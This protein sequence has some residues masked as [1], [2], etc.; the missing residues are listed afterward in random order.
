MFDR[1]HDD[2][3]SRDPYG[4]AL[5]EVAQAMGTVNLVFGQLVDLMRTA[6]DEGFTTGPGL[7]SPAQWL[8]WRAGLSLGQAQAVVR[9]A[10]RAE[11][12]PHAVGAL[13]AGDLTI[14]QVNEIARYVP[15]A[16]DRSA[17]ALAK[18]ATVSQ[19]RRILPRYRW[20]D[21]DR[22]ARPRR[23]ERSVAS[24]VDDRGWWLR[25][26][27]PEDEGAVVDQALAALRED[28]WRQDR[29][30]THADA[31]VTMAE[32]ALVAGQSRHP[33]SDR[34][35]I[36]T[37]LEAGP[38]GPQL[39]TH[40]GHLL[41][42]EQRRRLLC[43]ARLRVV[44]HEGADP[45][46][47]GRLTRIVP[48]KLRRSIEHRDGGCAVPGCT[49]T[50]GLEI[51]HLVHWEDGGPTDPDNLLCLCA[52]HHRSHHDGLLQIAGPGSQ[53]TF[54]DR[55]GRR[56]DATGRPLQTDHPPPRHRYRAPCGERM[57]AADIHLGPDLPAP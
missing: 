39:R 53:P 57:R 19:L 5:E 11:E 51:H 4:R 36:H 3:G 23:A 24:G 29:T 41:P 46:A 27:L 17:T 42:D 20:L 54:H 28:R 47:V 7:H 34:Y 52:A 15:A 1:P 55:H 45:A 40:L 30:T 32:S 37:H 38:D 50:I 26:R 56:L 13:R 22:P 10:R 25:A 16:Y 21:A 2:G 44:L 18:Q 9:V 12:L 35:Q 8:A 48:A 33:G 31:L 14:D 43:D 6:M 49:R